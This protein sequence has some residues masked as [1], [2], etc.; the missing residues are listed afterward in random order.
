MRA[1]HGGFAAGMPFQGSALC[2]SLDFPALLSKIPSGT[3]CAHVV[4]VRAQHAPPAGA[5]TAALPWAEGDGCPWALLVPRQA[6][7][8]AADRHSSLLSPALLR[9]RH[10][11]GVQ[12]NSSLIRY[13]YNSTSD[14]SECPIF[15][16]YMCKIK[17]ILDP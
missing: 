10:L 12:S 3:R 17:Q 11:I 9:C 15:T 2:A 5:V 1:L 4:R 14:P 13:D 7:A 16:S 6:E 8:L